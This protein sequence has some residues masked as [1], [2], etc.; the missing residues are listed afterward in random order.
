MTFVQNFTD[1]D[2]KIINRANE[3]GIT[4]QAVAEKYIQEYFTDAQ[5][6][7]VRPATIH[8]RPR[9]T[10]PRSSTWSRPSSTRATPIRWTT[11]TCT[12][13]PLK[14]QGYGK[15]SHQPIEDLQSGARIAV[16]DV[17]EKPLDFAL[18][19]AAKPGEPAW[20]SPG[21]Q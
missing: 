15:L 11:V 21:A 13:A 16:G 5:G 17:K 9:R 18:W 19:K 2:D 14:F 6:L 12:T 1:V 3:E 10:S 20:D 7:G 8:P 4:S